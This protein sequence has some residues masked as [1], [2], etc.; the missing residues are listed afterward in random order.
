MSATSLSMLTGG[1]T[2]EQKKQLAVPLANAFAKALRNV[3]LKDIA[4]LAKDKAWGIFF[5]YFGYAGQMYEL[6]KAFISGKE[7]EFI[8]KMVD[9]L[10]GFM[11]LDQYKEAYDILVK[12]D[13]GQTAMALAKDPAFKSVI[14]KLD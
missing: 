14:G 7:G 2:M 11:G 1:L 5:S 6:A 13:K 12:I 8:E 4:E 9:H 10:L 3:G